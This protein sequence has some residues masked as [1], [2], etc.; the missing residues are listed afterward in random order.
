[1]LEMYLT[2]GGNNKYQVKY[3]HKKATSW[4]TSI[5]AGGVQQNEAWKALN[6]TIPKTMKYPLPAMN[7]YEKECKQIM[8]PIVKFGLTKAGISS[9]LN[10]VVIYWP[11][12]LGGID[13]FDP[14]VIQGAV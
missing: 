12:S 5:R 6:Y 10:T 9:T 8:R 1:M 2:P 3:T 4:A 13:I 11:C 7:L 14:I